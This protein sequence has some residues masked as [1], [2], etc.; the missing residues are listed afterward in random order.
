M[1]CLITGAGK[2][3]GKHLYHSLSKKG[4]NV[5]V[6]YRKSLDFE[7][8]EAIF[9]DFSTPS[10]VDSFIKRYHKKYK[11]TSHVINNV[12]SYIEGPLLE[13]PKEALEQLFYEMF[14]TPFQLIQS[15]ST[16]LKET[17]GSVVN[18]GVAALDR[19]WSKAPAYY[20]AKK[21][22]WNLTQTF[23]KELAPFVRVNMLSPG[24]LEN[25]VV[26]PQ[27]PSPHLQTISFD[28]IALGVDYLFNS[29][30]ITGQNLEIDGG[31][32]L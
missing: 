23:A 12:G 14:F 28:E 25:S 15:L 16:A 24:Y 17:R 19:V 32:A 8:K 9:G 31:V 6:H 21:S 11:N 5:V 18:I 29:P 4:Y 26:A 2:G 10:G 7:V 30:S 1:W 3:L 22:L 13:T 27:D 20:L